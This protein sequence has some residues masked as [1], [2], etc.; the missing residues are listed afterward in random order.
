MCEEKL[1]RLKLKNLER[2]TR[3]SPA[4]YRR[5]DNTSMRRTGDRR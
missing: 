4:W 1:K 5:I 3:A 2:L